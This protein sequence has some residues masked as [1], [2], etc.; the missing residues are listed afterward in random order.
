MR[1][2]IWCG[3]LH[4][5]SEFESAATEERKDLVVVSLAEAGEGLVVVPAEADEG[6]VAA[7]VGEGSVV[8]PAEADE[9]V[10][11]ALVGEGSVVVPAE[12]DE[13]LVVVPAGEGSVVVSAGEGLVVVPAEAGEGLVVLPAAKSSWCKAACKSFFRPSGRF[14]PT[15]FTHAHRLRLRYTHRQT[16]MHTCTLGIHRPSTSHIHA[17]PLTFAHI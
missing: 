2:P 7:L 6:L 12:A 15:H 11:A 10:V 17:S 13:G 14:R 16:H 3:K 9:G 1:S 4:S 5:R 8:V